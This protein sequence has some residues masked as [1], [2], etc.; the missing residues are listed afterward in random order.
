MGK[1]GSED[2]DHG[3]LAH[4]ALRADTGSDGQGSCEPLGASDGPSPDPDAPEEG[5]H[6]VSACFTLADFAS[7]PAT[8]RRAFRL[9]Y[10]RI[11]TF[12]QANKDVLEAIEHAERCG[13]LFSDMLKAIRLEHQDWSDDLPSILR[14]GMLLDAIGAQTR[15]DT[16]LLTD[17]PLTKPQDRLQ[18]IFDEGYLGFI[19]G[20]RLNKCPYE[21]PNDFDAWCAGWRKARSETDN[22]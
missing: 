7:G 2:V 11:I 20:L 15:I 1:D 6:G 19:A 21:H 9:V 3:E 17:T 4:G 22:A 8:Q 5:R 10:S 18:C 14:V 16:V 13:V 12:T